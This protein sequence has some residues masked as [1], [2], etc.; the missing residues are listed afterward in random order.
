MKTARRKGGRFA[1]RLR[2][3]TRAQPFTAHGI[4]RWSH[5]GVAPRKNGA[6]GYGDSARGSHDFFIARPRK[7]ARDA[8][9]GPN[10]LS[11]RESAN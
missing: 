3:E 7:T 2:N 10:P 8:A 5:P 11:H 4:L 1:I 9:R 6:P